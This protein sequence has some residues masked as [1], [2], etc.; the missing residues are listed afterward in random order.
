ML[1]A[2]GHAFN[3]ADGLISDSIFVNVL[4]SAGFIFVILYIYWFIRYG[5]K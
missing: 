2:F 4:F 1:V 5:N 3:N